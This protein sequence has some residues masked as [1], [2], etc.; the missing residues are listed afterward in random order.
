MTPAL[1]SILLPPLLFLFIVAVLANHW[2]TAAALW[3]L[4][5]A[6]MLGAVVQGW[7]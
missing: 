3:V 1:F 4:M 2:R 7:T 6:T 5:T